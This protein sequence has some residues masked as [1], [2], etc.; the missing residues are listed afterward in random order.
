MFRSSLCDY[1]GAYILVSGTKTAEWVAA[2]TQ[3]QNVGK[4]VIIKK[5]TLFTDCISEINKKQID[6]SK[7]IDVIKPMYNLIVHSNNYSK[8]SES[9]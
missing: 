6:N 8:T 5:C 4:N 1:S 9:L 7:H 2:P 3:P